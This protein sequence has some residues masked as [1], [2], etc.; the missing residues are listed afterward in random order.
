[1]REKLKEGS[2]MTDAART[3]KPTGDAHAGFTIAFCAMAHPRWKG[4]ERT[5]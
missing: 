1:M 3:S 5:C 4:A 2:P